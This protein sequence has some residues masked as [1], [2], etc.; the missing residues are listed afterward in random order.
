MR[1]IIGVILTVIAFT[2][3]CLS[4]EFIVEGINLIAGWLMR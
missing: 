1:I 2:V 3:F 4:W